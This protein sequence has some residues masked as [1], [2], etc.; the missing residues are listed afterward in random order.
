MYFLQVYRFREVFL[1]KE[2]F[3]SD[4]SSKEADFQFT[5]LFFQ[6]TKCILI[7]KLSGLKQPNRHLVEYLRNTCIFT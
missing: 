1:N 7:S 4:R 2:F 6:K 5:I 3:H